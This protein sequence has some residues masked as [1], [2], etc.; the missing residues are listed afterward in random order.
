MF[1]KHQLERFPALLLPI[2]DGNMLC[3][4]AVSLEFDSFPRLL[5]GLELMAFFCPPARIQNLFYT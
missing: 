4:G 3:T 1:K 2:P 5:L